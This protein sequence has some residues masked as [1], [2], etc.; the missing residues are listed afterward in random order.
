VKLQQIS[1]YTFDFVYI[2][3]QYMRVAAY[4]K[5][6]LCHVFSIAFHKYYYH[7]F[8]SRSTQQNG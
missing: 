4:H 7:K 2:M 3:Q 5:Y 1:W 6:L 8:M